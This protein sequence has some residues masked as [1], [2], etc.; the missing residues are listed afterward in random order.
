MTLSLSEP[1]VSALL[2]GV[3]LVG[4][5]IVSLVSATDEKAQT[6]RITLSVIACAGLV[7]GGLSTFSQY[8]SATAS[9]QEA[10]TAEMKL[11]ETKRAVDAASITLKD[12]DMLNAVSP[13]TRYHVRLSEDGVPSRP[14]QTKHGIELTFPGSSDS[15]TVRVVKKADGRYYLFF[16]LNLSLAAAH[17]YEELAFAH[18]LANPAP[19]IEA[20]KSS[21]KEVDCS[22]IR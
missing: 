3:G 21:D 11:E 20:D 16:G 12:L 22:T 2:T 5:S 4:A 6:K 1:M 9:E 17:L 18:S 15:R 8:K 7:V 13:N 19:I 14:C 10:R